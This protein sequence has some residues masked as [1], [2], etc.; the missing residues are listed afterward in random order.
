MAIKL[1]SKINELL[2]LNKSNEILDYWTQN[3]ILNRINNIEVIDDIP[4]KHSELLAYMYQGSGIKIQ[5]ESDIEAIKLY[6]KSYDIWKTIWY[7]NVDEE[8]EDYLKKLFYLVSTGVISNSLAEVRMILMEIDLEGYIDKQ[9]TSQ[10]TKYLENNIYLIL[11]ILIR[12]KNGW[13]DIRLVNNLIDNL[14]KVQKDEEEKYLLKLDEEIQYNTIYWIGSL[15]NVLEAIEVY[16]KYI[17]TG[18]PDNVE[19]KITRYCMDSQDLLKETN[20]EDRKFLFIL[21]EKV[22]KKMVTISLWSSISGISDK[23]DDYV[24]MLTSESNNKPIFELWPSQQQAIS[25]NLFDTNKTALVVQ[26]PTSAGKTLIAKFYILQTL[27]LYS[28][29]KIAY[30]VPTRA[31][32]NQVKRDLRYDFEQLKINVEVSI[33]YN[34]IEGME[35]ELLLSNAD[36]IVTTPEKLDILMKSKN[37]FINKLR[38]LVVDEAHGLQSENRGAK[39]ELLLAMLR[40]ENRNIRILMLSPFMKNADSIAKWLSGDR[41]HD[42]YVDWKPSQQFTGIYELE[43]IKKEGKYDGNITYVPSSLNTMYSSEFKIKINRSTRKNMSKTDE[44]ICIAKKYEKLGGVLILCIRKDIAESL[45]EKLLE[46]DDLCEEKLYKLKYLLELVEKEMGSDCLL[47]KS[48]KKGCAYHHSALPLIIREEI[49]EAISDQLI[50]IV[51]ATTT[52]A[53]GMNFPISTVIFQGMTIPSMGYSRKMTTS[54]FWNIAGRAGRALVDKEGHIIVVSNNDNDKLDFNTY[55]KCK[56]QE[57]ISSLLKMLER[58]P[59]DEINLYWIK[60]CNELSALLQYIHHV[61]LVDPDVEIDDL[62]RGSLVYHQLEEN[63]RELGEK[64]LRLTQNYINKLQ[65]EIKRKKLMESIDK[66]GLSSVSMGM[67]LAKVKSL[68][69]EIDDK[70]IF[71]DNNKNLEELVEIINEI[72]EINLSLYN[73]KGFSPE[74]VAKITKD[75][76]KGKSLREISANIDESNRVKSIDDKINICGDYIYSKLINNLPWGISAVQRAS[77]ILKN[78]EQEKNNILLPSYVYFGVN[79]EEAVA[80]CMLGVP[81]FAAEEIGEYWR[82]HNGGISLNK[83]LDLKNWLKSLNKEMWLRCF[84]DRSKGELSYKI[85]KKNN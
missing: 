45:V 18:S 75:W 22:L 66:T 43:K 64:L 30:I 46:R 50:T 74:L 40:K 12:K 21:L 78:N 53:Q 28:E 59:E 15:L 81:R 1:E 27:S 24:K 8:D 54:E 65:S 55:L 48:I 62:L 51:A 77:A 35:E 47:Y 67:L 49:E 33:P 29:G 5:G 23:L 83:L 36:I 80:F 56:N 19:K 61:L 38:L 72:P 85:W 14:Q 58:V 42:I 26:M 70:E 71:N 73:S 63:N 7:T 39:L 34:D 10:W 4:T 84:K 3:D 76:V 9:D 68:G 57:V 13:D 82:K 52:L 2:N 41:G 69:I 31:L 16:K 32:V 79:T 60:E 44:A 6:K 25:K 17:L 37:P 20:Y 11:L